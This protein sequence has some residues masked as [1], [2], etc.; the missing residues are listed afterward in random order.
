MSVDANVAHGIVVPTKAVDSGLSSA[1]A[2]EL[3]GEVNLEGGIESVVHVNTGS[4]ADSSAN[5]DALLT[6]GASD[7]LENSHKGI[8]KELLQEARVSE[9][10]GTSILLLELGQHGSVVE[11]KV[12][13]LLGV[14]C[15]ELA[16]Q[17]GGKGGGKE[18]KHEYGG[19]ERGGKS[20]KSTTE[21]NGEQGLSGKS[22]A[23]NNAVAL[24][25]K[26]GG[27]LKAAVL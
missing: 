7:G 6:D 18:K 12:A 9:G 3:N 4:S 2:R 24:G 25:A 20:K 14:N 8:L 13:Q 17:R 5:H 22:S 10:N 15:R 19:R 27:E 16:V 1:L 21:L 11:A 26:A 23:R